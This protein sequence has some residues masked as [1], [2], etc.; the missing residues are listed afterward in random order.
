[1]QL[2]W[3][4]HR[5]S[6]AQ[7]SRLPTGPNLK[8]MDAAHT[9]PIISSHQ[10]LPQDASQHRPHPPNPRHSR[11]LDPAEP[12][13]LM[14][15]SHSRHIV[16]SIMDILNEH[17]LWSLFALMQVRMASLTHIQ[18]LT[19]LKRVV[20]WH[21]VRKDGS[22]TLALA[23]AKAAFED[24]QW[25]F[26]ALDR[27]IHWVLGEKT[28]IFED[29]HVVT[30]LQMTEEVGSTENDSKVFHKH[31]FHL[32]E[33]WFDSL[34]VV[35]VGVRKSNQFFDFLASEVALVVEILFYKDITVEVVLH[36]F[37]F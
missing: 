30:T 15:S 5:V 10:R 1:M 3:P 13:P 6:L 35:E 26:V 4:R 31:L 18:M 37:F 11:L 9:P 33:L 12:T 2:L 23:S 25:V 19:I 21:Q 8:K 28:Q 17:M 24:S 32:V 16:V 34:T 27:Q 14:I 22:T 36:L 7:A 20:K 29:D